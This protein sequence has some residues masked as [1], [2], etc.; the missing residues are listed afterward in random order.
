MISINGSSQTGLSYPSFLTIQHDKCYLTS[1]S[2]ASQ[3]YNILGRT[4]I[5]N[6]SD[7]S[8]IYSIPRYFEPDGIVL[9]DDGN[10]ILYTR[11]AIYNYDVFEEEIV[12]YYQGENFRSY[13]KL[14][15]F[16]SKIPYYHK[17]PSQ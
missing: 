16:S 5:F 4:T 2:F 13:I 9:S 6:A 1:V 15:N 12:L 8:L 14:I 10:A 17:K 3:L 11:Y 7:S